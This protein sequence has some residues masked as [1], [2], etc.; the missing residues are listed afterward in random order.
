MAEGDCGLDHYEVRSWK[1]W[2]RHVTLSLLARAV[3][4]RR[5]TVGLRLLMVLA[6]TAARA[7]AGPIRPAAT[8]RACR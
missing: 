1:G 3:T 6:H 4:P 7:G 5:R 8:G 2:Y